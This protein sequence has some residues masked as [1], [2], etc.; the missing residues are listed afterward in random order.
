[1][2]LNNSFNT[3]KPEELY[4]KKLLNSYSVEDIVRQ[5]LSDIYPFKCDFYIKSEDKYIELN[6]HWTHGGKPY[7]PNDIECQNQLLKWQE[8]AKTSHFYENAIYNWTVRDVNKRNIA[9]T[10]NLNYVEIFKI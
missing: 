1:M 8:K 10:N 3:S 6:L 4:Y 2:R 5:Y 9:K 7:N